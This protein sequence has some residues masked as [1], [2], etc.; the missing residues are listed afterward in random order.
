MEA[1]EQFPLHPSFEIA[2]APLAPAPDEERHFIRDLGEGDRVAAVFAVR[3]RSRMTRRNGEDFLK[4]IV[5]DRTGSVEAVAWEEVDALVRPR[6]R[7]A[8]SSASRVPSRAPAL[9][10]KDHD[11]VGSQRRAARVRGRPISARP[12]R[13]RSSGLETDLRDLIETIQDRDLRALLDRF[14]GPETANWARFRDAPAAKYYHQA[15]T[16]GLLE[17]SLT[18]AQAV[19]AAAALFPGIDR[20]TAVTG[21]LLHDFGKTE[22]YNS[23][24][25]AIDLTDAGRLL[26]E[27][28][29]GYYLVRREI[30]SIEGFDP[31]SRPGAAAR[32][33]LP[34]R[35]ARERLARRP[36]H[37]RG[38]PRPHDGQ[39][40]R[41]ARQLRPDRARAA[42]RPE[43]VEVRP[44][45]RLGRL[46]RQQRGLS[47]LD[48]L[49][50]GVGSGDVAAAYRTHAW[51]GGPSDLM[52]PATGRRPGSS[53]RRRWPVGCSA[54]SS[55]ASRS[56]PES[57][58]PSCG[59]VRLANGFLDLCLL[60]RIDVVERT[61]EVAVDRLVD[62][63]GDVLGRVERRL[64]EE[65]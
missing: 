29:I 2:E 45:P 10:G 18:V 36:G 27:I 53:V 65:E 61:A 44:R 3:E 31:S 55:T 20:E 42:R 21:A 46:L 51:G 37:A 13:F 26:G 39:P 12:R 48:G 64:D 22:A 23:D 35:Q 50:A 19:S 15:Y 7:R 41:H 8:R 60:G 25:L 16:H 49:P 56:K 47:T 28:P 4:L 5:A 63:V 38:D 34:P 62:S 1:A 54:R 40:R 52:P 32:N 43:L 11:P 6:P 57:W 17:H 24:P 59:C 14:F 33:P 30:E 58:S 9:R